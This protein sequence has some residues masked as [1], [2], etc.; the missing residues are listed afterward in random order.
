MAD[1]KR[2]REEQFANV[3][4][5]IG[6]EYHELEDKER[7]IDARYEELGKLE[8]RASRI[9]SLEHENGQLKKR[10]SRLEALER[11]ND[12]L[13]AE[14]DL[15]RSELIA[16]NR[17]SDTKL[18]ELRAN[19]E[20][21]VPGA[22]IQDYG[23]EADRPES[24]P[25]AS[26]RTLARFY[27]DLYEDKKTALKSYFVLASKHKRS[28][29]K[30]KEWERCFKRDRFEVPVDGRV[31]AFRRENDIASPN[32]TSGEEAELPSGSIPEIP[33]SSRESPAAVPNSATEP[34]GTG[35]EDLSSTQS[36][37]PRWPDPGSLQGSDDSSD[38]PTIVAERP[39]AGKRPVTKRTSTGAVT[40]C[41]ETGSFTRPVTVKSEPSS[42]SLNMPAVQPYRAE[43][44]QDQEEPCTPDLDYNV[45][46]R[47]AE[48]QIF[49]EPQPPL[50]NVECQREMAAPP[51]AAKRRALQPLDNNTLTVQ[52]ADGQDSERTPKRRKRD[53]RGAAAVPLVAEDGE[54][55]A[56]RRERSARNTPN[57]KTST[58]AATPG[59]GPCRLEDLLGSR[60]REKRHLGSSPRLSSK[61]QQKLHFKAADSTTPGPHQRTKNMAAAQ[62]PQVSAHGNDLTTP[63]EP[64]EA[65]PDDE[66]LRA[67]PVRRLGLEHFKI[68]PARNQGLD[69]AFQD[70]V[71]NKDE[72]K[73][74]SG[75]IRPDCCGPIFRAMAIEGRMGRPSIPETVTLDGV[76]ED[77]RT[78]LGEFLGEEGKEALDTMPAAEL[79]ELLID[80]RTKQ[81]A[82]QFGKHRH[83]H[84][85][86]RSPPGFWRT[87]MPTTQENERD[88][89]HAKELE[90]IK[91][92]ERYREAM[93]PGGRWIF[94]DE[95]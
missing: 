50:S 65:D 20:D 24:V 74:L 27:R 55:Q 30:S 36:Q 21:R 38:T 29:A 5:F 41:K 77:D 59:L 95:F 6:D 75:C 92:V 37:D 69:Y 62:T 2:Q 42:E 91:V 22:V 47:Q 85:R 60:P 46:G 53:N 16:I 56:Y 76:D 44:T 93:K 35:D 8:T 49:K 14:V 58:N 68:D 82:D 48:F 80:A 12:Q 89:E 17:E 15:L 19:Q 71:R 83:A 52:R 54:E 72:R 66:P 79:R 31:V 32:A 11:D 84:E 90:R 64:Y 28:N 33:R 9:E 73:C 39:V 4:Q 81:L 7:A 1:R 10:G 25:Y 87:D 78:V 13:R 67:R 43:A 3:L 40:L 61:G 23:N 63:G 88:R 34:P 18:R 45:Q 57:A 86:A 26:Y 70:V 51:T 94:A